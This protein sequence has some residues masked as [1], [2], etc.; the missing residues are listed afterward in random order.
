[1]ALALAGRAGRLAGVLAPALQA[2]QP[3]L[4]PAA[5]RLAA[6]G[7]RAI[8][9][10]LTSKQKRAVAT[11]PVE[12]RG[13]QLATYVNARSLTR[14]NVG[15]MRQ[16]NDSLPRKPGPLPISAD[17]QFRSNPTNR[18]RVAPTGHGYY[19]AFLNAPTDACTLMSIGYATG[20]AGKA[21]YTTPRLPSLFQSGLA[22]TGTV[23][24]AD[25]V[26]GYV[27]S[28]SPAWM[29]QEGIHAQSGIPHVD[30]EH[31]YNNAC[32]L[33]F[34]NYGTTPQ[35][36]TAYMRVLGEYDGS[37]PSGGFADPNFDVLYPDSSL[38]S[39]PALT[40]SGFSAATQ[41][42]NKLMTLGLRT[43]PINV[44]QFEELGR[45]TDTLPVRLSMRIRNITENMRCGGLVHVLRYAGGFQGPSSVRDLCALEHMVR[46][47]VHTR[48]Y[49]GHELKEMHQKNSYVV[50]QMRAMQ[51]FQASA[52]VAFGAPGT[53]TAQSG[54]QPWSQDKFDNFLRSPAMT[55]IIVLIEPFTSDGNAPVNNTYEF[56]VA[57]QRLGRFM[58][59]TTLHAM[60]H[61]VKTAPPAS[62]NRWRDLEE[63]KL[64]LM[65]VGG[66]SLD[67]WRALYPEKRH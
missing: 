44:P 17:Q 39:A 60:S 43:E 12:Q 9:Q 20:L 32:M 36:G 4:V 54:G 24:H 10:L 1:M 21:R 19:D 30:S 38:S 48:S 55:P 26:D 6:Q 37:L 62:I 15:K 53:T 41:N 7:W 27:V 5:K 65:K 47:S 45:H 11:A 46:N 50:D 63:S 49:S 40:S 33:I 29:A 52:P 66:R 59:G 64:G 42:N 13:K 51:F 61:D 56:T 31:M 67:E 28:S 23:A 25:L 8:S 35:V 22:A 16:F 2:A 18:A 58:P 14:A 34:N 57:A 3:F